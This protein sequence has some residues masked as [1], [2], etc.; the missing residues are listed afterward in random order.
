MKILNLKVVPETAVDKQIDEIQS[1]LAKELEKRVKNIE[2]SMSIILSE[3]LNITAERDKI[4][5]LVSDLQG[6][7]RI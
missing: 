6:D 1:S 7:T 4:K 2:D 5:N 3:L